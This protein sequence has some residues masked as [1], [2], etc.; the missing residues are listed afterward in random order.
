MQ[1][2]SQRVAYFAP[3]VGVDVAV[4]K[5]KNM[6][7]RWASCGKNNRLNIHWKCMMAPSGIIDYIVVHELCHFHQRNH[8]DAFWNEVDQV[9]P[10]YRERKNWLRKYGAGLDI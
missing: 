9:M 4:I 7:Y 6:R 1:R 10:D 5:V 3:K 2:F 8:T